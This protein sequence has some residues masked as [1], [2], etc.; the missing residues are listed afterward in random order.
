ML[1]VLQ[2]KDL[3]VLRSKQRPYS[4]HIQILSAS[5]QGSVCMLKRIVKYHDVYPLWIAFKTFVIPKIYHQFW[6]PR[7][8]QNIV[9]LERVQ[10]RFT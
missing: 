4:E 8:K 6:N 10:T 7:A 5:R 2:F 9:S 1:T 3:C